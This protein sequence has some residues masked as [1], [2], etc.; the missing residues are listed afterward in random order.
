MHKHIIHPCL[1]TLYNIHY[2]NTHVFCL[3][4]SLS[5]YVAK[6]INL[7]INKSTIIAIHIYRSTNF[8]EFLLINRF[9]FRISFMN[10]S[11]CSKFTNNCTIKIFYHFRELSLRFPA[12]TMN[13]IN[14]FNK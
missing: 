8:R 7:R 12:K 5:Y 2:Y 9:H 4:C 14:R 6:K 1:L 3:T 11:L 13:F 10:K